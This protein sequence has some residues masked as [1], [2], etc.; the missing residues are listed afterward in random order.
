MKRKIY[1]DY[2]KRFID[3]GVSLV[4]LLITSPILVIT[5]IAIKMDSKGDVLFRQRRLGRYGNEFIIYKFRSMC[6][7]AEKKGSGQYSFKGD[8]RV[9]R[10]GKLIRAA[11]IDELPQFIN[12][13]KGDMSLIGFRPPLTYHPWPIEQYTEEQMKM[14]SV[15]PG[16]TGWAQVHGRKEVQWADRIE[17]GIWYAE[18]VSFLLDLKILILTVIKVLTNANNENTVLTTGNGTIEKK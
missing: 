13:I 17:M 1:R 6:M 9:T 12:I 10:I 14:F 2:I 16:V 3:V 18:H 4:G 7:D 5:A 8:P 11:S 15:R